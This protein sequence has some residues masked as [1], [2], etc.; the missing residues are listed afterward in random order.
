MDKFLDSNQ[1]A[2]IISCSRRKAYEIIERLPH[3]PSPV[4]VSERELKRWIDEN[5]VYP[6]QRRR[7]SA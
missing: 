5:M 2:E 6:Q 7:R 1:V 4:R 3:L